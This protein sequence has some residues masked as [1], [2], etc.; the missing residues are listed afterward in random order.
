MALASAN[1]ALVLKRRCQ[2]TVSLIYSK[3]PRPNPPSNRQG[4]SDRIVPGHDVLGPTK[5]S[6]QATASN[7]RGASVSL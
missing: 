2:R 5:W 3:P 6:M 1:R 7:T 4:S